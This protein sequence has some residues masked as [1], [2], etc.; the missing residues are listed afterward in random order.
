MKKKL[1]FDQMHEFY[2]K[3]ITNSDTKNTKNKQ[4]ISKSKPLIRN[5]KCN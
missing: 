2:T 3:N 5:D 1:Y 4:K